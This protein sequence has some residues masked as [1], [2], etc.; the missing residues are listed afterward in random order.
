MILALF[1]LACVGVGFWICWSSYLRGRE[2]GFADG[3]EYGEREGYRHG[4]ARGGTDQPRVGVVGWRGRAAADR[5]DG[6]HA[7]EEL[8]STIRFTVAGHPRTKKTSQRIITVRGRR[9]I[10]PSKVTVKWSNDAQLQLQ[11]QM[12]KYRG[13]TFSERQRWNLCAVFYRPTETTA[14][15]VNHLQALCDVLQA[16]GVVSNDRWL[17]G[18]DGSRLAVDAKNPRVEIT[19][20]EMDG[21]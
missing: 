9:R 10:V 7:A 17:T 2:S 3:Y 6:R 15:L 14:D 8:M 19:L 1:G 21:P 18:F 11:A 12:G 16:A 4:L 5:P 13:H 20:N